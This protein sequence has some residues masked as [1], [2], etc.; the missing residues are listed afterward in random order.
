M[1]EGYGLLEVVER[2]DHLLLTSQD[3]HNVS[4][5]PGGRHVPVLLSEMV[6]ALEVRSGGVYLD[7]TF[8]GGG[9][10]PAILQ[11][12][13]GRLLA[14]DRD[15]AAVARGRELAAACPRFTMIDGRCRV[16][17]Q[18]REVTATLVQHLAARRR[19]RRRC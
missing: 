12:G 5:L 19:R 17:R 14:I 3:E 10:S 2:Q 1:F 8:G 6:A 13:A 15:P 4:P 7:A 18:I 9:Y 16:A 11:A